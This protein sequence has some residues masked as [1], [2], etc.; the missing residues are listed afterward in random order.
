MS[1]QNQNYLYLLKIR[2]Q[3][4]NND[5]VHNYIKLQLSYT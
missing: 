3:V 2:I 1:I 5:T 4:E